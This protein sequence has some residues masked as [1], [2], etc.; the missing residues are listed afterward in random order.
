MTAVKVSPENP[1]Y[2]SWCFYGTV[3]C[4]HKAPFCSLATMCPKF[5]LDCLS[6]VSHS[7][8]AG[9]TC[10]M[11]TCF[12]MRCGWSCSAAV[13][14]ASSSGGLQS[15]PLSY[16]YAGTVDLASGAVTSQNTSSKTSRKALAH[17]L[18]MIIGWGLLLPL[19][20]V[21]ARC[22]EWGLVW[23]QL[24]RL[25]QASPA[26]NMGSLNE[27]R[28][29]PTPPSPKPAP[30]MVSSTTPPP[31]FSSLLPL[32]PHAN[33]PSYGVFTMYSLPELQRLYGL[34]PAAVAM[35]H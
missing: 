21:F 11:E 29:S 12:W 2:T 25:C 30:F 6:V 32:L 20:V 35:Q 8:K 16:A 34:F 19:G 10:A 4:W 14:P 17:A 31:P 18:L 13:G 26:A 1:K 3:P 33:Q 27:S 5:G 9:V 23:F 28:P 15:H 24:H 22:K 7:V